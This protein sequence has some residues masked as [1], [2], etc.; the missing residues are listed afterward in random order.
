[1]S[2]S[3]QTSGDGQTLTIRVQDRFDF[4]VHRDLR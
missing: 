1:M 3:T 4:N 2:I